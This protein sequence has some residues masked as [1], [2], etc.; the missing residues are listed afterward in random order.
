[1][2]NAHQKFSET[3]EDFDKVEQTLQLLAEQLHYLAKIEAH[4]NDKMLQIVTELK[5][6]QGKLT[7]KEINLRNTHK[8]LK[9]QD[10]TTHD[11]EAHS[12]IDA[13]MKKTGIMIR[14]IDETLGQIQHIK[15]SLVSNT[16]QDISTLQLIAEEART[17]RGD[18]DEHN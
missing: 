8:T 7:A 9:I 12:T 18:N 2:A 1:M 11:K 5:Q 4:S 16:K 3:K 6:L 13:E 17:E 14:H 10:R 15:K